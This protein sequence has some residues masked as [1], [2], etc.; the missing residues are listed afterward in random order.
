VHR[1]PVHPSGPM[2]SADDVRADFA[3][4]LSKM[5]ELHPDLTLRTDLAAFERTR[6]QIEAAITGPMTRRDAWLLFARLN[7]TLRDAHG[8]IEMPDRVA[9]VQAHLDAGGRLFPFGVHLADDGRLRVRDI[10][11]APA[12]SR[13]DRIVAI[14]GRSADHIVANLLAVARG[15][16]PAMRRE[17]IARRF[18][19]YYWLMFGD[20]HDYAVTLEHG[21]GC[22]HNLTLAGATILAAARP[23]D[24]RAADE[25]RH[26]ILDGGI[27][28]LKAGDF[29]HEYADALAAAARRAFTEFKARRIRA[30]IID[31]RDNPGGDDP[32]WQQHLMEYITSK[33]Y[34]HVGRFTVRVNADN[35]DPGDVIGEVQ[36]NENKRR[37][38]PSPDNPLRFTGPV[39]VLAGRFTYSSAIQFLV[40]A[41][42]FGIARIAGRETGG[43]SCQTG[44]VK[45]IAMPRTGLHAFT[46]VIAFTRPSGTGCAHGVIPDIEID[47]DGLDPDRAPAL[48]ASRILATPPPAAPAR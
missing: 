30:L 29:G 10:A 8:G 18:Q 34:T 14:N 47:D 31:V 43:L 44:Q 26:K 16:T 7:P 21:D 36:H 3:G 12:V 28:Y 42:D 1:A 19:T 24:A 27:G 6:A 25:F 23:L 22:P 2:L 13:G 9:L 39:Y 35:A 41:Q 5:T 32:L 17:L 40:A 4:L 48:L 11:G 45:R 15:D 38:T 37:F 20:A 46:P 33:S